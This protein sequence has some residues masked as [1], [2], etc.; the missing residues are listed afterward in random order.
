MQIDDTF[1]MTISDSPSIVGDVGSD[2]STKDINYF[3]DFITRNKDTL[4]KY[5]DGDLDTTDLTN[6]LVF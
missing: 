4:L 2:L 5:W 3:K 6:E 1:S